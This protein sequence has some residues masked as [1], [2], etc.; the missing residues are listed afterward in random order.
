MKRLMIVLAMTSV[1]AVT[2]CETAEDM[3]LNAPSAACSAPLLQG[4]CDAA[5]ERWGFDVSTGECRS[6]LWGGCDATANNYQTLAA[7]QAACDPGT[8]ACGGTAGEC[9]DAEYCEYSGDMCPAN[10]SVGVC[11]TRPVACTE[12][13][14]PVCGCDGRTYGNECLART[15]GVTVA[16]VGECVLAPCDGDSSCGDG[17]YCAFSGMTCGAGDESGVCTP[18]PQACNRAIDPACGC[19]GVTYDNECLANAAGVDIA[20]AGACP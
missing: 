12:Q 7:C 8:V 15:A 9:A 2:G 19:D 11:R 6:F 14:D 13:Y 4:G 1:I 20:S 16:D 17:F 3:P 18:R 10:D 5:F